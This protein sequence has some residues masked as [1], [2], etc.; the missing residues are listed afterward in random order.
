MMYRDSLL[1]SFARALSCLP[2]RTAMFAEWL[3]PAMTL[4]LLLQ[5]RVV[6]E[7][8]VYRAA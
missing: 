3:C 7:M 6:W 5:E 8:T 1:N 2:F 4:R